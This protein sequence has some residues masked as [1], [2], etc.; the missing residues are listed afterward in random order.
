MFHYAVPEQVADAITAMADGQ[1]ASGEP[2]PMGTQPTVGLED[3]P[4]A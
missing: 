2:D 1:R 3:R 4:A